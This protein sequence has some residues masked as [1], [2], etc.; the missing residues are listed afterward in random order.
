MSLMKTLIIGSGGQLGKAISSIL[1]NSIPLSHD[2]IDLRNINNIENTL[3][4][5]SFD[6]IINC[7]AMTSVD[8]CE[9]DLDSA[10]YING[11]SMKYIADYCREN[12]NYQKHL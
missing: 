6:T 5:Y 7:A 3:D 9:T 12:N 8:K 2:I 11:L 4:K 10:Y 1:E